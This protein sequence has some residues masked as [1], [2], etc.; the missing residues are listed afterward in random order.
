M[1]NLLIILSLFIC[2]NS[3]GQ[4]GFNLVN[5]KLQDI[6]VDGNLAA[7]NSLV[8]ELK[9][10]PA[11]EKTLRYPGGNEGIVKFDRSYTNFFIKFCKDAGVESIV[12]RAQIDDFESSL[13]EY[14]TIKESGLNI[15]L[16]DF[17]NEDYFSVKPESG[18]EWFLWRISSVRKSATERQA[19]EY[20]LKFL[21]FVEYCKISGH[22]V[23][24]LISWNTHFKTD[25][26]NINW[27]KTLVNEL[28][29]KGFN[30]CTIHIYGELDNGYWSKTKRD[31]E[32]NFKGLEIAVTEYQGL[33]FHNLSDSEKEKYFHSDTHRFMNTECEKM[34]NDL[35][36]DIRLIHTL[37]HWDHYDNYYAAFDIEKKT[38]LITDNRIK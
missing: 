14:L 8:G 37:F 33:G 27:H 21:K 28:Q 19:K 7:Y 2:L 18:L 31:I 9:K 29:S 26:I 17:G 35:G 25:A 23:S 11:S 1:K 3:I 16:I 36:V 13:N 10:I 12:L 24:D 32:K 5:T 34:L 20:A 22:D 4:S 15:I 30:K 38:G 6:Y